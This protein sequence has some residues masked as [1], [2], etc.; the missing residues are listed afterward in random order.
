MAGRQPELGKYDVAREPTESAT[1]AWGK[2]DLF[3][4]DTLVNVLATA[5]HHV[6]VSVEPGSHRAA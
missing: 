6:E 3:S 2:I 4:I 1:E 5:G